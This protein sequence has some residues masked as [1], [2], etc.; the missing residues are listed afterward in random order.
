M[1]FILCPLHLKTRR[2]GETIIEENNPLWFFS[3]LKWNICSY[4]KAPFVSGTFGYFH[5]WQ[6]SLVSHSLGFLTHSASSFSCCLSLKFFF[7]FYGREALRRKGSGKEVLAGE[8]RRTATAQVCRKLMWG[9]GGPERVLF[10]MT[11]RM[12][13]KVTLRLLRLW[14]LKLS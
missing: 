10:G 5:L 3:F 14:G 6:K 12:D 9:P 4:F 7:F 8:E 1:L 11:L 2:R 13:L